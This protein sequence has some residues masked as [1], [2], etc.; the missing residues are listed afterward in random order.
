[1]NVPATARPVPTV[2]ELAAAA[3]AILARDGRPVPGGVGAAWVGPDG[4]AFELS[5]VGPDLPAAIERSI[6]TA[7][8]IVKERPWTGTYRLVVRASRLIVFDLYWTPGEPTRIMGLSR[9]DWERSLLAF[10][11]AATC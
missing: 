10:A 6:A 8:R 2:H 7:E 4:L 3:L 5:C 1:M 9:G 11:P